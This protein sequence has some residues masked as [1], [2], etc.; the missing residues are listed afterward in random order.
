M[1]V[2]NPQTTLLNIIKLLKSCDHDTLLTI[3]NRVQQLIDRTAPVIDC[4]FG[5]DA[6]EKR[7]SSRYIT[8]F[9]GNIVR[10]TNVRP[11]EQRDYSAKINDISAN[12]MNIRVSA[13]FIPSNAIKVVFPGPKGDMK[14]FFLK[15]VRIRKQF[16][17]HDEWMELGCV[18]ISKKQVRQQQIQEK[19]SLEIRRR[20]REKRSIRILISGPDHQWLTTRIK[21]EGYQV[22]HHKSM[23][24]TINAANS[25]RKFNL[26]LFTQGT[27]L[28]QNDAMLNLTNQNIKRIAKLGICDLKEHFVNLYQNGFDECISHSANRDFLF[29]SIEQA[30]LGYQSRTQANATSNRKEALILSS[31]PISSSTLSYQ[32]DEY[33]FNCLIANSLKECTNINLNKLGVVFVEICPDEP[34]EL[35]EVLNAFQNIP[36][37]GICNSLSDSQK[38]MSAGCERYIAMPPNEHDFKMVI[39]NCLK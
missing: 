39:E 19:K 28:S 4:P 9:S 32:L 24:D 38:A 36:V 13:D 29:Y 22:E 23:K 6:Q 25:N 17:H 15:I 27:A 33:G 2:T 3:S 31:K 10:L 14:R 11:G 18:T 21:I 5:E 37:I 7:T 16:N 1:R 34:F 20:L 8:D 26:I 30:I 12:G 35:K